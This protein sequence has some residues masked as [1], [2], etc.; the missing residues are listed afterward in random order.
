MHGREMTQ[1][2]HTGDGMVWMMEM[3]MQLSKLVIPLR[4]EKISTI[5]VKNK[6]RERVVSPK[7]NIRCLH[8]GK[9]I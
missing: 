7:W 2:T 3:S 5:T 8:S 9:K 4:M 6:K 1:A